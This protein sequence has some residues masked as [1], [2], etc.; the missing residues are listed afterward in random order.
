MAQAPS[1]F[2]DD[3]NRLAKMWY[4][5]SH[6]DLELPK[7]PSLSEVDVIINVLKS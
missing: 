7:D 4:G 2:Y 1:I 6:P 5:N 3:L